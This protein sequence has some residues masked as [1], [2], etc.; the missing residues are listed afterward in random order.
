M[1]R[2][3]GSPGELALEARAQIDDPL[4]EQLTARAHAVASAGAGS[5]V[6]ARWIRPTMRRVSP[7]IAA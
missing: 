1:E 4:A 5:A 7:S 2:V 3:I 6:R